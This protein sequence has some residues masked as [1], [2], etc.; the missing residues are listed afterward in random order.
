MPDKKDMTQQHE[1]DE[2]PLCPLFMDGLPSDFAENP[3]LAAIASLMT[4]DDDH[5]SVPQHN[6]GTVCPP[7]N[8]HIRVGRQPQLCSGGGKCRS[9]TDRAARRQRPYGDAAAKRKET[10]TGEA[11][12]FLKMWK[13]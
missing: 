5:D 10:T 1:S 4:E 9:R 8:S 12:L 7:L 13:L 3:Q 2:E 11:Q 6:E